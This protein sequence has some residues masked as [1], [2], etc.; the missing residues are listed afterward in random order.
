M[1]QPRPFTTAPKYKFLRKDPQ[2]KTSNS[3]HDNKNHH[4]TKDC[5]ATLKSQTMQCHK[6]NRAHLSLSTDISILESA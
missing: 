5:N 1:N 3:T 6:P 2:T 4:Y